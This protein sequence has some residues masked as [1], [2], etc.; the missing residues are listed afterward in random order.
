MVYALEG[1]DTGWNMSHQAAHHYV[2]ILDWQDFH[3]PRS[4]W[5][6]E[7]MFETYTE[8][9]PQWV[10]PP[11]SHVARGPSGV[12]W[13]TGETVPPDLQSKFLL[14]NYRGPS[15]N[16]TVLTIGIEPKGAGYIANHEE[17]L[18]RGVGITDVELG[19]DGNIYLCDFGGG[20]QVNTNGAIHVLRSKGNVHQNAAIE[21]KS[22][23][24][25]GTAKMS[26]SDL[27]TL[28]R[29]KDYR[30]R[31]MAQFELVKR[32]AEGRAALVQ[33]ATDGRAPTT[34]R[35]H[36]VWGLGQLARKGVGT[37]ELLKL[38]LDKDAEVVAN[39][40]RTLGH[41]REKK[42]VT[43]LI[44][45]LEDRSPRVRSLAA[46]ALGRTAEPGN[47]T[48]VSALFKAA[49]DNA[50]R[51][52]FDPVLRHAYLTALDNVCSTEIAAGMAKDTRREA[53]ML[54]L[55]VLRRHKNGNAARFLS[56]SDKQIR[57]EAI[58]AVY[59]TGACDKRSGD[60]LAAIGTACSDQPATVQRR[61]VAANYRV[62]GPENAKTLVKMAGA[63]EL[64][65][66]VR[67]AALIG[68]RLWEAGVE[69]DPVLGHYRPQRVKQRSMK[70]LGPVIAADLKA[71]LAAGPPPELSALALK[72]A[73]ESGV[74]LEQK[75]LRAQI[76]NA[77]LSSDVRVAALD[78]LVKALGQKATPLV[79]ELLS[80]P[81][82]E[83]QAA[84]IR[85]G[86]ALKL[87]GIPNSAKAAIRSA[88]LPAA[89]AAIRGLADAQLQTVIQTW[90]KRREQNVRKELWLDL[91][92]ELK[93]AANADHVGAKKAL[94]FFDKNGKFAAQ[95]LTA[96][97][98]DIDRGRAVFENQGAC[99][100][101]HKVGDKGGIQGPN[102]THVGQRQKP[103][104]LVESLVDPGAVVRPD[105]GSSTIT[106]KDGKTIVGRVASKTDQLV[107]IVAVNG[108]K[109]EVPPGDVKDVTKPISAM[110]PMALSLPLTDLRDLI[111]F[112]AS[113]NTVTAWQD[114]G[115]TPLFDGK[116]LDGWSGDKRY[117]RVENG[118]IV[119]ESTERNPLQTNTFLI[120]SGDNAND[121]PVEFDNFE[122][123]LSYRIY[124]GN[125]GVQ[126]RSF[127]LPG[128]DNLGNPILPLGKPE[129]KNPWRVA[130]YQSEISFGGRSDGMAWGENFRQL[131]AFPGERTTI[132]QTVMIQRDGIDIPKAVVDGERF[133]ERI[134][135]QKL[136]NTKA[137]EWN[138]LS[139]TADGTKI[140]H[141]INNGVV[142]EVIDEDPRYRRLSGLVALQ[143]H[144]GKP[145]K[146]EFKNVRIRPIEPDQN[147]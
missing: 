56:D 39:S 54:A 8:D 32:G 117:W 78:S 127:L 93:N 11:A 106:L 62:A 57:A 14:A 59:D 126:Y 114:Q 108:Q 60:M 67:K 91:Y 50:A 26:V 42:A 30:L 97:G 132:E 1:S 7:N 25:E 111:A 144:W 51:G 98:G 86:F 55:L 102:L 18:V 33:A 83:L 2:K 105:Y 95:K 4:M 37:D 28:L 101:C 43:A 130:G 140:S 125:S 129:V 87:D 31:Q 49:D 48:V 16:C 44:G 110:P 120:Y 90:Y 41:A 104:K 82:G 75:I 137:G 34:A 58:R 5:V 46:I 64:D 145:M 77:D 6:A 74:Q 69:T 45:L 38:L 134:E 146:V 81:D 109:T 113:R 47:A 115:W 17:V 89:R 66:S 40:A 147:H 138:D 107:T 76:G 61:I 133:A 63:E 119:G 100:Q 141:V 139:I 99:L 20:W 103:L 10:Y 92:V 19:Y 96:H 85:N 52:E 142:C 143:L 22:L 94:G 65:M 135:M 131:L 27:S 53:R 70:A 13:L 79:N 121:K 3:P 23:F 116:T 21:T 118:L 29:S 12:T 123:R 72:L 128:K 15:P 36:G 35:L 80:T 71:F 88:P 9:Q 84:A 112:L 122:L 124:S 68:L 73:D 24:T 136:I